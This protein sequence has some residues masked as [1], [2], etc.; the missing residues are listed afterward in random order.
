MIIY[1]AT[2][3]IPISQK[4]IIKNWNLENVNEIKIVVEFS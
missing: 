1:Q 3:D 4:Q 2:E